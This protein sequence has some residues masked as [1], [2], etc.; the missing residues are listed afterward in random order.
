MDFFKKKILG[1]SKKK[2]SENSDDDSIQKNLI[3]KLTKNYIQLVPQGTLEKT[4]IGLKIERESKK[5]FDSQKIKDE[6][7]ILEVFSVDAFLGFIQILDIE[8]L[9]FVESSD[10]VCKFQQHI[11]YKVEDVL[12]VPLKVLSRCHYYSYTYPLT[13]RFSQY[14]ENSSKANVTFQWNQKMLSNYFGGAYQKWQVQLIQGYIGKY[15]QEINNSEAEFLLISRRSQFRG[16]TRYN[17]RGADTDGNT[18]NF[19]E[20]EQILTYQNKVSSYTIIR[21]SIPLLW[22]Q[23]GGDQNLRMH[24]GTNMSTQAFKK[25]FDS[26]KEI[27]K[28]YMCVNLM[29]KSHQAEGILTEAFEQEL[30]TQN[31]FDFYDYFDFNSNKN[32]VNNV[33]SQYRIEDSL[34]NKF[35]YFSITLNKQIDKQQNGVFRINCKDC[36]DRTNTYMMKVSLCALELIF[37]QEHNLQLEQIVQGNPLFKMDESPTHPFLKQFKYLWAYNGDN[38]SYLYAGTDAATT[39]LTKK[40]YQGLQNQIK[41]KV[42][43]ANVGFKR[44]I[45][46][47]FQDAH[48]QE[49][50]NLVAGIHTKS[51]MQLPFDVREQL[52]KESRCYNKNNL[53]IYTVTWNAQNALIKE[54]SDLVN[55]FKFQLNNYPDIIVI[56]LQEIV[57]FKVFKMHDE[58]ST[59]LWTTM[60]Q[61][62]LNKICQG[63]NIYG[64][65]DRRDMFGNMIL[66]YAKHSVSE[67]ISDIQHDCIKYGYVDN[68]TQYGG[69]AIHF[70][71]GDANLCFINVYLPS[72]RKKSDRRLD[73]IKYIHKKTFQKKG[74]GKYKK[75]KIEDHD[76]AILFGDFNFRI[77]MDF[78]EVNN[79]SLKS[80]DQTR[81][82]DIQKLLKYDELEIAMKK[83]KNIICTY[84]EPK[85]GFFPTYNDSSKKQRTAS[86]RSRVLCRNSNT[87]FINLDPNTIFY[88]SVPESQFKRQ[89]GSDHVPVFCQMDFKTNM[90]DQE[91]SQQILEKLMRE[92]NLIDE[93]IQEENLDDDLLGSNLVQ[94]DILVQQQ[95]QNNQFNQ[96]LNKENGKTSNLLDYGFSEQ[97]NNN[98]NNLQAQNLLDM[99]HNQINDLQQQEQIDKQDQNQKNDSEWGPH[100]TP[101]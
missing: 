42:I 76:L 84:E 10:E 11:F 53:S 67:N 39:S 24:Q 35:Q 74:V 25:H 9:L 56:G 62:N 88:D 59:K 48:K 31:L 3:V 101:Q 87:E 45:Q 79:I 7:E 65:I 60:I 99:E 30:K 91:K 40:G 41:H 96:E 63:E 75:M 23:K 34:T 52:M 19:V 37:K 78:N 12:F 70:K 32:Q 98:L 95:D 13:L 80:Q 73:A 20:T 21:G 47:Q 28:E 6:K 17:H 5:I 1:V 55:L 29:K 38:I 49:C 85:I 57:E 61:N 14:I 58:N 8:Y 50:L 46:S 16:G 69:S 82:Q 51:N 81:Q 18:S 71:F 43:C 4:L 36:L 54:D 94:S 92:R 27:Y 22:E 64:L 68:L 2:A 83:Q 26:L 93:I 15:T 86:W 44:L 97:D 72:G 89:Y 90:I 77:D 33:C 100:V 66:I